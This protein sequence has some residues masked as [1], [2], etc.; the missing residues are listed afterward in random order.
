MVTQTVLGMEC[1]NYMLHVVANLF[2]KDFMAQI[3]SW[4]Q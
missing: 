4:L 2:F 3:P 1:L